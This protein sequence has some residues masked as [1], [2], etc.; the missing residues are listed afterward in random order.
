MDKTVILITHEELV[1]SDFPEETKEVFQTARVDEANFA[2]AL[3]QGKGEEDEE[4]DEEDISYQQEERY[5]PSFLDNVPLDELQSRLSG[6]VKED[7]ESSD[8][9]LRMLR[10]DDEI[11]ERLREKPHLLTILQRMRPEQITDEFVNRH[12]GAKK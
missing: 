8:K 4:I 7:I 9:V 12:F 3:D 5:Y 6:G 2:L 1:E 10:L 11:L